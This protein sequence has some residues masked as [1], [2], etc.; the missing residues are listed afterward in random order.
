MLPPDTSA[1]IDF[2]ETHP[3]NEQ[4]ILA[5][6]DAR[7]IAPGEVT[8]DILKEYDQDHYGGVEAVERLAAAAGIAAA[9]HVLDVCSGMGG[10]ARYLAHRFGCRV[11]GLD[12]TASRHHGAVR[13]TEMAGLSELVDFRLGDAMNMPF[14]DA[15]FD[16]VI[17]QEA[18]AH[19]PSKA[20]LIGECVRIVKPGRVIAFTDIL[21]RNPLPPAVWERLNRGM[22]FTEIV[23]A[24]AYCEL[25]EQRGC[26]IE[27]CRD[28][29]DEWTAVL[30][31]RLRMYRGMRDQT[32]AKLGE[33][34][35]ERYDNAY[36]FFV[37]LYADKL[38]GGSLIVA[39]RMDGAAE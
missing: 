23:T 9:D 8:E 19:V 5:A 28:L 30:Q 38:L 31:Q 10:P 13:L 25:L 14:G 34:H 16:K 37:S 33:A 12:L 21:Q 3:I 35:Y 11:T 2:Y 4:Q 27:E 26:R 1:V 32:I 17:G 20:K 18:W 29:S 15:V 7:G 36:T 22:T 39:R 6:L 24:H